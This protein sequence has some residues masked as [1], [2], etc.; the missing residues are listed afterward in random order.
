METL[1][2]AA[3]QIL[4]DEGRSVIDVAHQAGHSAETCLRHY[5]RVFAEHDPERRLRAEDQIRA[6]RWR[7]GREMDA[8]PKLDAGGTSTR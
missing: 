7:A 6:A 1:I 8:R 2:G 3:V 4:I 5:A